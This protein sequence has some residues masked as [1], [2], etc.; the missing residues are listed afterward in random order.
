MTARLIKFIK[1]CLSKKRKNIWTNRLIW[2]ISIGKFL[3]PQNYEKS[4][5]KINVTK[6][7]SCLPDSYYDIWII[8]V[9]AIH[10]HLK[11]DMCPT[12]WCC[13]LHSS[14]LTRTVSDMCEHITCG[15]FQPPDVCCMCEQTHSK[16]NP[17]LTFLVLSCARR[18][19][20]SHDITGP[21]PTWL[22]KSVLRMRL[23]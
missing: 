21:A 11:A 23:R 5:G 16:Q 6:H 7:E 15:H 12:L 14:R 20:D 3:Q 1:R 13:C 4:G 8:N 18:A 2:W 22:L 17:D 10:V 9:A 19:C